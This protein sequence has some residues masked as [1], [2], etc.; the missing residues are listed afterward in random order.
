MTFTATIFSVIFGTFFISCDAYFATRPQMIS[1]LIIILWIYICEK[2][3]RDK[4]VK[5]LFLLPILSVLEINFHSSCWFLLIIFSLPFYFE[6]AIEAVKKRKISDEFRLFVL[7]L[8]LA[9]MAGLINP[10]GAENLV[11]IANALHANTNIIYEMKKI[12]LFSYFGIVISSLLFVYIL[13]LTLTKTKSRNIELRHIFFVVGTHAFSLST[14]K[15]G[16]YFVM[17]SCYC[18]SSLLPE[19][20]KNKV[21]NKKL[22]NNRKALCFILCLSLICTITFCSIRKTNISI[23]SFRY[24]YYTIKKD[25]S[26]NTNIKNAKVYTNYSNGGILEY[27]GYKCYIDARAEVFYKQMNKRED[28]FNEFYILSI[29]S[30]K[31]EREEFLKKYNFTNLF[32]TNGDTFYGNKKIKGYTLVAERDNY[33]LYTRNDLFKRKK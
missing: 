29:G 16:I 13:A 26:K 14:I 11:Y 22:D 18:I 23:S 27:M 15:S 28:I 17:I 2:Y 31:L 25:F 3:Y 4:K 32:I 7:F 33:R 19:F 30:G 5:L 1:Y 21:D 10:Y 8:C 9:F 6:Y 24:N 20:L 12:E